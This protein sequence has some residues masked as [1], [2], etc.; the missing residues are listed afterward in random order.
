MGLLSLRAERISFI[1]YGMIV[2]A[3]FGPSLFGGQAYFEADLINFSIPAW[4]FVGASLSHGHWPLWCPYVFGGQPFTA[5]PNCM[6][7]YPL[8]YLYLLPS[9]AIGTGLFYGLHLFLAFL[10]MHLWLKSLGFSRSACRLG[11]AARHCSAVGPLDFLV[12]LGPVDGDFA[13][14]LDAQFDCVAVD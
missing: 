11:N 4:D 9:R 7:F 8:A 13:R 3:A 5:D 14:C 12:D 2:L 6:V 10:G 1:F